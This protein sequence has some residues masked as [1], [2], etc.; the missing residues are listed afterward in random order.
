M[1]A[2]VFRDYQQNAIDG[3]PDKIIKRFHVAKQI[4]KG[5]FG[6]VYSIFNYRSCKEYA[7]KKIDKHPFVRFDSNENPALEAEMIMSLSHPCIVRVHDFIDAPKFWLITMEI[8]HGGD[9]LQRLRTKKFLSEANSKV[10][11]YQLVLAIKYLHERKIAHHDIKS[12]KIL[13]TTTDENTLIKLTDF[14]L[15]KMAMTTEL[16][17][18]CGTPL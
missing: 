7:M 8:V 14:G 4:G 11:F 2:F 3:L 16:K 17:T 15:S 18:Y 9:L 6:K 10:F 13:L 12:G 1:R 5:A